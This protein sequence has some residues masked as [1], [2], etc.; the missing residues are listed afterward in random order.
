MS[1]WCNVFFQVPSP[2]HLKQREVRII[3]DALKI[4]DRIAQQGIATWDVKLLTSLLPKWET[5]FTLKITY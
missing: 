1:K 5:G 3:E 4:L 2:I